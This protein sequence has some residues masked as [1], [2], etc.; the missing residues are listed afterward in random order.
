LADEASGFF[1]DGDAD[2]DAAAA[3]AFKRDAGAGVADE[4]G[5]VDELGDVVG[6]EFRWDVAAG[7]ED[8]VAREFL[9]GAAKFWDV[10]A[11]DDEAGAPA[12]CGRCGSTM[13]TKNGRPAWRRMR[14]WSGSLAEAVG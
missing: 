7:V 3:L 12:G 9:G 2:D 5:H 11:F 1:G 14:G 4:G 10:V 13:A 6:L 8:E